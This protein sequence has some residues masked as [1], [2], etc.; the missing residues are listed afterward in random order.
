[1]SAGSHLQFVICEEVN[2]CFMGITLSILEPSDHPL[3]NRF[4]TLEWSSMRSGSDE[5]THL[6]FCSIKG[7]PTAS[8]C[9]NE[10]GSLWSE[11]VILGC[12][13]Q[14]RSWSRE[15]H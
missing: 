4:A 10:L 6:V 13:K 5:E 14:P 9:V 3:V 7:I 1:M 15:F 8:F 12:L 2:G 11:V